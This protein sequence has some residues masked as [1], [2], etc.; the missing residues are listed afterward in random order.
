V[1]QPVQE[2]V[3]TGN[4]NWWKLGIGLFHG[5]DFNASAKKALGLE[6]LESFEDTNIF[7]PTALW[8]K[9]EAFRASKTLPVPCQSP[10]PALLFSPDYC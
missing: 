2:R 6:S 1:L 4:G 3:E 10:F 7:V 5:R 9:I 8:R